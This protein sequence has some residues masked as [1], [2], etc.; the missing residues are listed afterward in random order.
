M[1]L[2][3]GTA[4]FGLDYG[5]TNK[6]GKVSENDAR[7]I[8][9]RAAEAGVTL[10]DTAAAYGNAEQVLGGACA[11][12]TFR[13]VTKVQ[14]TYAS[15]CRHLVEESA[16]RLQVDIVDTVLLHD[17]GAVLEYPDIW[18]EMVE[19]R[20]DGVVNSVGV[21]LYYPSQWTNMVELCSHDDLPL[22][23]VVQLPINVF[24]QRFVAL[25]KDFANDGVEV[26]ARSTYLQG[27]AFLSRHEL[28]RYLYPL[29][30][31]LQRLSELEEESGIDR[32]ALL[33]AFVLQYRE[34][35][36]MVIG[37]DGVHRWNET[38]TSY[39]SAHE[40][41]ADR[42]FLENM[43]FSSLKVDDESVI[44]PFNWKHD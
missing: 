3:I 13:V 32:T 6:Q 21:S 39:Q 29:E 27:A 7:S 38:I 20:H 35:E 14:P 8:L 37:I 36:Y 31:A 34:I 22:P 18:R 25:L 44:L 12:E 24:D 30:P 2:A 23:D 43:S 26:H 40:A 17:M 16:S 4:Q 19:L 15:D 11:A 28:P 9:R 33:M 10:L 1:R 42:Q 41:L 5:I